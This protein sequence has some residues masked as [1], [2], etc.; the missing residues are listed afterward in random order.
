MSNIP[1]EVPALPPVNNFTLSSILE[2]L[3]PHYMDNLKHSIHTTNTRFKKDIANQVKQV[4][5]RE[6]EIL[7]QLDSVKREYTHLHTLLH[8]DEMDRRST[9]YDQVAD[10]L[11]SLR[12]KMSETNKRAEKLAQRL[13]KYERSIS[14]NSNQPKLFDMQSSH[15][16][17]F[18]ELFELGMKGEPKTELEAMKHR[19]YL[20]LKN[21]LDDIKKSKD[22]EKFK[23]PIGNLILFGTS[24]SA[25]TEISDASVTIRRESVGDDTTLKELKKLRIENKKN[26]LKEQDEDVVSDEH[27]NNDHNDVD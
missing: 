3:P 14:K 9:V 24:S 6:Q 17:E 19:Q 4:T 22:D 13:K 5:E 2:N 27:I 11:I 10:K 21:Q 7:F 25:T 12:E 15:K 26:L 8:K 16:M 1:K 23:N 18:K 20:Y